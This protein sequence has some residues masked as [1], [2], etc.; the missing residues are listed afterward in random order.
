ME[1]SVGKLTA[2][3]PR[4][5]TE[6]LMSV[7]GKERV[8]NAQPHPQAKADPGNKASGLRALQEAIRFV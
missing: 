3:L 7:N 1:I 6:R 2:G 5:E 8:A 4:K